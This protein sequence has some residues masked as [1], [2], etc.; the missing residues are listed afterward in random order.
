MI[1]TVISCSKRALSDI[2]EAV[3]LK[4]FLRASPRPPSFFYSSSTDRPVVS[5]AM[6]AGPCPSILRGVGGSLPCIISVIIAT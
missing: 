3:A 2:L 4:C 1:A 6:L 5:D